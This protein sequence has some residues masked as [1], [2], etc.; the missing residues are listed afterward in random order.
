MSGA[1][2]ADQVG[3]RCTILRGGTSKGIY[4]LEHDIPAPGQARDDPATIDL[5][6]RLG[7]SRTQPT[8]NQ[9]CKAR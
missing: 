6:A 9:P 7:F 2:E 1:E 8:A 4:L 3:L 5:R